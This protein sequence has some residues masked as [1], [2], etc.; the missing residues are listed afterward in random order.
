MRAQGP[1]GRRSLDQ[2]GFTLLELMVY[3]II[4]GVVMGSVY[5]VLVGQ[6]RG[7]G[8]QRELMDVH[9]TLRGAASLL[10]WELRQASAAGGD[11]YAIGATTLA[12]R[13]VQ[14][15][16]V[17]C[18][19]H[20]TSPRFGLWGAAGELEATAEDSLLVF[21][22]GGPGV[23]DDAWKVMPIQQF[24]T[25]ATLGVGACSWTGAVVPDTAV[26]VLVT[27]PSDTAGIRVGAPVRVF[28]RIEYG[29][30]QQGGRWWL[31]RKVGG[32]VTYSKLTGPL[33][34]TD[35]LSLTYYDATGAVTADPTQV[36]IVE[37]ILRAESARKAHHAGGGAVVQTDTLA[38]KVAV[39]G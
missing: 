2:R 30:F 35:G 10:A 15:T 32:A 11:L 25:P 4:A 1:V 22:A 23:A 8:K 28:R 26:A 13:G 38:T 34:A 31:G 21:S 16:A 24:G 3:L 37:I 9:E 5:E 17:V 36:V 7:Y 39:R 20:P 29:L 33:R 19:R 6:M 14:G 12:L 18:A 27:A